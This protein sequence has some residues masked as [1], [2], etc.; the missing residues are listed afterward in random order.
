MYYD[1]ISDSYL[2][3]TNTL[4]DESN[5]HFSSPH[6]PP[7]KKTQMIKEVSTD[8]RVLCALLAFI[9]LNIL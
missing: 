8:S 1:T 7:K 2:T 6:S 5:V 3:I 9:L 4:S